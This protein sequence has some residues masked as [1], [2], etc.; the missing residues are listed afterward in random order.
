MTGC[1]LTRD[2]RNGAL[3]WL[4]GRQQIG[5]DN[6]SDRMAAAAVEGKHVGQYT[7]AIG[8]TLT[9]LTLARQLG[10]QHHVELCPTLCQPRR[11]PSRPIVV[12]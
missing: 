2:T 12:E 11:N 7:N 1:G 9:S 5:V 10:Q 4:L 3:A 8:C 6:K